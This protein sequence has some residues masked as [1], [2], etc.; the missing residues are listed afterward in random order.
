MHAK[1]TVPILVSIGFLVSCVN[2]NPGVRN[3]EVV[4]GQNVSP[5]I[6]IPNCTKELETPSVQAYCLFNSAALLLSNGYPELAKLEFLQVIRLDESHLESYLSLGDIYF[7]EMDFENAEK[8]Y[9]SA[10][11][12]SSENFQTHLNLGAV[13]DNIGSIEQ[14]VNSYEAAIYLNPKSADSY[15]N[16]GLAYAKNT[17][18]L[19]QAIQSFETAIELDP[20]NS[21]AFFNLGQVLEY[22]QRRTAALINYRKAAVL[23][24]PEAQKRI[25]LIP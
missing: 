16:L 13:Y 15:Y 18:F 3:V 4:D 8:M 9:V 14:A 21:S 25:A 20:E 1:L 17:D 23:G 22:Q 24:H 7:E 5:T 12:L 10:I 19:D 6:P 2:E 11:E